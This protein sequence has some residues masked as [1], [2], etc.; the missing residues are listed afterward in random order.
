MKSFSKVFLQYILPPLLTFV[1]FVVLWHLAVKVFDLKPF[2]V[3]LP[4]KVWEA[5][6]KDDNFKRLLQGSYLTGVAAVSGFLISLIIGSFTSFLFS[7]SVM[8]QRAL[9]PYAI[10]F[11]TV[12][13][14]AIAPL[15]ITWFGPEIQS[16]IVIAAIIS[17]FPIITNVTTGLTELDNS[18][19]ELFELHRASRLQK[20]LKLQLPNSV[21]YLITGAKTSSGL[22]VIGAIIGEL[23]GSHGQ[24]KFGLGYLIYLTSSQ[25][26]LDLMFSAII[27][28]TLLGLF[29]FG[30]VSLSGRLILLRWRND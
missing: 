9:Y 4:A 21:P 27:A 30:V 28:S 3:P 17:L 10:F 23:F 1:I 26:K 2:Q 12:P 20:L 7:Q 24:D 13:I 11:Q 14:I 29:I 8:I 19:V 16:I 18:M 5:T 25:L 22:S 15:I 6:F